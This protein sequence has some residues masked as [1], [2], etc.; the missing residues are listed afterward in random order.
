MISSGAIGVA[1]FH[2]WRPDIRI[3]AITFG[4]IVL[5]ILPWLNKLIKRA[6]FPGG[7]KIEFQ[8][9]QAAGEKVTRGETAQAH[10]V[11]T[12]I[13]SYVEISDRDPNLAL[14]GLRIEI[15]RRVRQLARQS[16]LQE[17]RSL[18]RTI[19]DLHRLG[20]LDDSSVS[21][22]QELVTAGNHSAHG[23]EV[24]PQAAAWAIDYGPRVLAALDAKLNPRP[25]AEH[26]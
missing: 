8:D 21:G 12:A 18:T 24:E 3:D 1:V 14:V 25:E 7:W 10:L 20:V 16:G 23:A 17:S 22:L 11:E 6:E 2:V 9:V 26:Q 4:L 19:E 5:A 15:E 13:P